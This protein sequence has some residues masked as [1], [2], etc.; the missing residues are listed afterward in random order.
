LTVV[1]FPVI[2]PL[3]VTLS[4]SALIFSLF[5]FIALA[6][7][8]SLPPKCLFLNNSKAS[9]NSISFVLSFLVDTPIL[10]APP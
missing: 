4:L 10:V 9:R 1:T 2:P 8:D 6:A 5:S 7:A 3:V